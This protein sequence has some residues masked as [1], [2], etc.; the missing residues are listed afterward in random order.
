MIPQREETLS[1]SKSFI[2][3]RLSRALR[4]LQQHAEVDQAVIFALMTR[5]WQFL[6]GPISLLVIAW[7]LTPELQGF[8]Y[9]FGS[10]LAL[11]SF[12]ELAF[13][14]VI[15]NV[16]SHEWA[17]LSLDN[18]GRIVGDPDA[19][20]RLISMGRLIFKWYAVVSAIF[21]VGVGIIGY[22]F[23]SQQPHPGIEWKGPWFALVILTSLVLWGLPFNSL[24]EGCNQIATIN[25]F[26]LGQTIMENLALWVTFALGGGLWAAVVSAAVAVLRDL[27]LL[28]IQYRRFFEPFF[29]LPTG[30]Q[31]GWRNEIW[32]MQWRL[33]LL[34]IVNYMA[35]SLFNPVMFHYQ[36]AVVAGQMGMTLILIYGVQATASV[37]VYT[38][39]PQF[40]MLIS[41]KEY[42]ALDRLWQ[43]TS[44]I[45]L[46]VISLGA[47][48]VWLLV[49]SLNVL[50]VPL[51]HRLI[52]PLP[53]GMF[54][55]AAILMQISQCQTTY[56]R[57]HK[58]EPTVV[59][60]V[61]SSISIGILVWLL[62]SRY[63]PLG[64]AAGNLIVV[65]GYI[66]PYGTVIWYRCRTAWHVHPAEQQPASNVK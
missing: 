10:L 3:A 29:K 58:R 50:N 18:T 19:L 57:A 32:P 5:G 1:N 14:L 55:M 52:A 31:I 63:G 56:L 16:S 46:A 44:L 30:A 64:A 9:T 48:A 60:G 36:G 6:A 54:A 33:G 23:F 8:Y 17:R 65:A 51:A 34:G 11:Q 49:Y 22:A 24:L 25:R 66:V 26:R 61:V 40:G 39:A 62:G 15:I 13:Y 7:Y 45:S 42:S 28:F 12:V 37:W 53:T 47:G 21:L 27:Y 38:K 35:F 20:S 4:N 2:V 59:L 41:R 43:R